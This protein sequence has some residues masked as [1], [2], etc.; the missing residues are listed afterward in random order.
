VEAFGHQES[1]LPVEPRREEDW[2]AQSWKGM[3]P[4]SSEV[5]RA[6]RV[7]CAL[8]G[9]GRP[10]RKARGQQFFHLSCPTQTYDEFWSHSWQTAA[11]KKILFL[12]IVNRGLPACTIATLI[13]LPVVAMWLLKLLPRLYMDDVYHSSW[14]MH[15][16]LLTA[17][18]IVACWRPQK[19]VFLDRICIRQDDEHHKTEGLAGLG[20]VLQR[21][22]ALLVCWD[23]TYAERLFC[24][25]ELASFLRFH[26][27]SHVSVLEIKPVM[28]GYV[29]LSIAAFSYLLALAFITLPFASST[30]AWAA[31]AVLSFL[32]GAFLMSV[33]RDFFRSLEAA[34]DQ[35]K[36][37]SLEKAA[38]HCCTVGH[39]NPHTKEPLM[40][41][42][43]FI[44]Q[45]V[46]SWYGSVDNFER[47]VQLSAT[48]ALY[49]QLG[50]HA[51]PYHW[52]L[53][54][55]IP[56]LWAV[57]DSIATYLISP[58]QHGFVYF[59]GIRGVAAWLWIWPSL[60]IYIF[61]ASRCTA[62]KGKTRFRELLK[63]LLVSCAALPFCILAL[64]WQL[65]TQYLSQ[66]MSFHFTGAPSSLVCDIAASLV[67]AAGA[68]L[69]FVTVRRFLQFKPLLADRVQTAG[70]QDV[71]DVI[72]AG[73]ERG[74]ESAT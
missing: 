46:A 7:H 9:F 8:Q 57:M 72:S 26:P 48:Q 36:R 2:R 11:W 54:S 5:L 43:Q 24:V 33:F 42:R 49:Q 68:L 74:G 10:F 45:C 37:F 66:L 65:A 21:S 39:V 30:A 17:L 62:A 40:C 52:M 34:K 60:L 67:F 22:E 3:D 23:R 27:D 35:L 61:F 16:G 31:A 20:A 47:C 58:H 19:S 12:A 71:V 73:V 64:A 29:A 25:F 53:G 6:T 38:C 14:C 63:S 4:S 51:F 1:K 13:S 18:G 44:R 55:T 15:F 56:C 41:D 69:L 70:V 32:E 59:W 28:L 50:V